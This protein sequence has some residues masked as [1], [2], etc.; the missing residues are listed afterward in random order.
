[1]C[2]NAMYE[3]AS[4]GMAFNVTEFSNPLRHIAL[5]SWLGINLDNNG[6]LT[7][8]HCMKFCLTIS[9]QCDVLF[10]SATE[11]YAYLNLHR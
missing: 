8:Q 5:L 10:K 6:S 2:F 9:L 11:T 3:F 7:V 1:M 4:S